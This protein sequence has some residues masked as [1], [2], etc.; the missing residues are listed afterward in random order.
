MSGIGDILTG[1]FA[2]GVLVG[3]VVAVRGVARSQVSAVAFGACVIAYSCTVM[4]FAKLAN[5]PPEPISVLDRMWGTITAIIAGCALTGVVI[6][7]VRD[8]GHDRRSQQWCMTVTLLGVLSATAVYYCLRPYAQL[9]PSTDF[10][11]DYAGQWRIDLYQCLF[12]AWIASPVGALGIAAGRELHGPARWVTSAGGVTGVTW[13]IW[14]ITGVVWVGALHRDH[15][16]V[17]SPVSVTLGVITL[18]LCVCGITLMGLQ[19]WLHE[20]Q[21]RVLYWRRRRRADRVFRSRGATATAPLHDQSR[22]L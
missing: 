2:V 17:A 19:G 1:A 14:K 9:P 4:T 3:M 12:A 5:T 20:R 6:T 13:G 11:N 8:R 15:L 10:L 18:V 16:P 21:R 22:A 7:T